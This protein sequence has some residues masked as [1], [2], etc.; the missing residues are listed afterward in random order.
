MGDPH[1]RADPF[2]AVADSLGARTLAFPLIS[3]GVYGWPV[4]DAIRQAL[5]VLSTTRTDVSESTLVLFSPATAAL[6]AEVAAD[7]G[8]T[9]G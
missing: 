3:A 6:A 1:S 9:T 4:R 2:R 7:L 8:V 5:L